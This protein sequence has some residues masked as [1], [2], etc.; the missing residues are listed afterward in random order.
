MARIESLGTLQDLRLVEILKEKGAPD[1]PAAVRGIEWEGEPQRSRCFNWRAVY[2]NG[3][4]HFVRMPPEPSGVGQI[5][6][7]EP[8][9]G[10]VI[11]LD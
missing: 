5:H 4:L 6:E 3:D 11:W 8:A 10:L 9:P 2:E 1:R 7:F